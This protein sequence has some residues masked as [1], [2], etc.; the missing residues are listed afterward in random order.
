MRLNLN[1]P[2]RQQIIIEKKCR[3]SKLKMETKHAYW[4]KTKEQLNSPEPI[5]VREIS[6]SY[7]KLFISN[8]LRELVQKKLNKKEKTN[9]HNEVY[10]SN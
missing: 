2:R 6:S 7:P 8:A 4:N 1:S 10:A 9:E 5:N 3:C